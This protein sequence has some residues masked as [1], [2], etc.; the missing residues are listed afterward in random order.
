M[1]LVDLGEIR[2]QQKSRFADFFKVF[3]SVPKNTQ[4]FYLIFESNLDNFS[5]DTNIFRQKLVFVS[6][7][8]FKG[9]ICRLFWDKKN[10]TD[11]F[12]LDYTSPKTAN[13]SANFL[14]LH[15]N[16][17][18]KNVFFFV[19]INYFFIKRNFA[20]FFLTIFLGQKLFLAPIFLSWT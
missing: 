15:L 5:Y 18:L 11:R 13:Q 6:Y 20:D 17:G 2:V 3:F 4:Y 16:L 14:R 19:F 9:K 1:V 8:R 10:R 12:F 7:I